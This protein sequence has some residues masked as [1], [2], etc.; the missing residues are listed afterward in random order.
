MVDDLGDLLHCTSLPITCE[1]ID[2]LELR[3]VLLAFETFAPVLNKK[4]DINLH[5]VGSLF[6]LIRDPH[7][8]RSDCAQFLVAPTHGGRFGA[9]V[10]RWSNE[11]V[12]VPRKLSVMVKLSS[13]LLNNPEYISV[14]CCVFLSSPLS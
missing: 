10:V 12:S 3:V 8:P 9:F 1:R 14:F 2:I 13:S 7:R 4:H 11:T 5:S 6:S